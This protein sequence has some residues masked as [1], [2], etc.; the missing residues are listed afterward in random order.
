MTKCSILT[1]T[2]IYFSCSFFVQFFVQFSV[3]FSVQFFVQF[4]YV[5]Q[6]PEHHTDKVLHLKFKVYF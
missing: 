5:T 4:F 1:I 2:R 3:Q 6:Y